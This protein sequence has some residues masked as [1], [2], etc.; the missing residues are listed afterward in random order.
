M[1][2]VLLFTV[3]ICFGALC[4]AF[5]ARTIREKFFNS[6]KLFFSDIILGQVLAISWLYFRSA[7][8]QVL[9]P[10]IHIHHYLWIIDGA[11]LA[12]VLAV[13]LYKKIITQSQIIDWI[14][15]QYGAIFLFFVFC[16]LI[17]VYELPRVMM[18][19]TDPDQHLYYALKILEFGKIPF[20]QH[21]YGSAPFG[22]PVGFGALIALW[23]KLTGITASN[24]ITIQPLLQMVLSLGCISEI[25]TLKS[26]NFNRHATFFITV[27]ICAVFNPWS[28]R[29]ETFY[30]E[31]T[32]RCCSSA[33]VTL[34][35]FMIF[36]FEKVPSVLLGCTLGVLGVFNPA[37]VWIPV[38]LLGVRF[39]LK[40]WKKFACIFLVMSTIFFCEPYYVAIIFPTVFPANA[41]AGLSSGS[42]YLAPAMLDLI[43]EGVNAFLKNMLGG[44]SGFILLLLINILTLYQE[45][46][47]VVWYLISAPL[48][49]VFSY[50]VLA[51]IIPTFHNVYG[52]ALLFP[53]VL[54]HIEQI[55][56]LY[57]FLLLALFTVNIIERRT[58]TL[59]FFL[60]LFVMFLL[61]QETALSKYQTT[62]QSLCPDNQCLVDD[63]L[64]V[65]H[66]IEHMYQEYKTEQRPL[67]FEHIPKILVANAPVHVGTEQWLLPTGASRI[68]PQFKVFPLA[69]YYFQGSAEYSF[70]SYQNHICKKLD[71]QWLHDRNIRYIFIPSYNHGC[72]RGV[73]AI[74]N[75]KENIIFQS[76]KA[77]FL[78][79]SGLN[80]K[81]ETEKS[82]QL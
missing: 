58:I 63:D 10:F 32:A 74:I 52:V 59:N 7:L 12:V 4:F 29:S 9:Q 16:L 13:L 46:K 64:K 37:L 11:L 30:F 71:I 26:K 49:L 27:V 80:K 25:V 43:L 78:D 15:A 57:S 53:Y 34:C 22:Y 73:T 75:T 1:V 28:I 39:H 33:I 23:S 42:I 47:K 40:E 31:G 44:I 55:G 79:I 19:S 38:F 24:A 70:D 41:H 81:S 45:Q 18:L 62:R 51:F 72:V 60:V 66:Q 35:L 8:I 5:I 67:D 65:I 6:E 76:G 82:E 17:V 14:Q 2:V 48:F 77:M 3:Q 50:L 61:R 36:Y 56:V 21:E 54:Q 20:S 68:L 69:F